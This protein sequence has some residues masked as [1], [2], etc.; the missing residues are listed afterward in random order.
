MRLDSSAIDGCDV[1]IDGVLRD[2]GKVFLTVRDTAGNSLWRLVVHEA[3]VHFFFQ[4]SIMDDL[5]ALILGIVAPHICLVVSL[6]GNVLP[7]YAIA[8]QFCG[9]GVRASVQ[10]FGNVP[11]AISLSTIPANLLP[12][13]F[14]ELPPC[15]VFFIPSLLHSFG[16]RLS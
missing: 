14:V 15:F 3:S 6:F 8:L 2:G 1:S 11:Q 12:I 16:G 5:L 4:M 7:M 10:K 9:N 13:L